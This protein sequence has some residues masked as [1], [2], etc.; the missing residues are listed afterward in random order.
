VIDIARVLGTAFFKNQRL[1]QKTKRTRFDFL[2]T[3]NI[4]AREDLH[5]A[6]SRARKANATVE[7][8]LQSDFNVSKEQI[9]KSLAYFLQDP[10]SSPTTRRW[11]SPATC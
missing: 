5:E 8:V 3:N 2:I 11:R 6:M 7:A 4:I 10:F 1:A 9:G